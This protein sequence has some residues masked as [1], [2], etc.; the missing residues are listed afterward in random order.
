AQQQ[1]EIQQAEADAL[2]A[3]MQQAYAEAQ[4]QNPRVM[5]QPDT[6]FSEDSF[7]SSSSDT[8]ASE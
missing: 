6:E 3:A 5:V 4:D 8:Q 1:D 2:L 7:S